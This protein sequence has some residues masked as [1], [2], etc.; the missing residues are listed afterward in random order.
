MMDTAPRR[1]LMRKKAFIT[2]RLQAIAPQVLQVRVLPA[3]QVTTLEIPACQYE[4]LTVEPRRA[5]N[6][7]H[8]GHHSCTG[9]TV[10]LI[11]TERACPMQQHVSRTD[12]MAAPTSATEVPIEAYPQW[13]TSAGA[14]VVVGQMLSCFAE[15]R[16][17]VVLELLHLQQLRQEPRVLQHVMGRHMVLWSACLCRLTTRGVLCCT[18]LNTSTSRGTLNCIAARSLPAMHLD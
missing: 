17:Q 14:C 11:L 7:S 15:L 5:G 10:C 18:G 4:Q 3:V 16:L 8:G 9:M 12:L 2:L 1:N 13:R 6:L